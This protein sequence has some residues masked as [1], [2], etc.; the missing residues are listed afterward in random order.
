MADISPAAAAFRAAIK[1]AQEA[2]HAPPT[3]IGDHAGGIVFESLD[4]EDMADPE[5]LVDDLIYTEGVHLVSGHPGCG[6][7]TIVQHIAHMVMADAGH[8]VWLDYEAGKRGTARRLLAL[9]IPR[10][11]ITERFHYSGWPAEAEK[12][13]AAVAERFPGAL[14]VIDSM[15]KALSSG[16]INENDNS[17]VTSW[18]VQVVKACKDHALP[19]V[20]IDHITKTGDESQ[21]SRGAGSKLA[22][23]DV[24]WRVKKESEFNRE[25]IGSI[26]LKQVKDREGFFPFASWWQIGDGH[27]KLVVLPT[28]GPPDEDG[29][30][31]APGI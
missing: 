7:T 26:T 16:G 19:I 1:A 29:D 23:V 4:F 5:V 9:G 24:H 3:P 28:D 27:G 18:T 21:Y 25:R 30:P 2:T 10:D 17:E 20:I 14:V 6:K 22:D 15:S 31:D 8:V 12:H 11:M 13:L